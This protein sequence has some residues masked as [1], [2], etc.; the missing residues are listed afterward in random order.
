[1]AQDTHGNVILP[2]KI[3]EQPKLKI[4]ATNLKARKLLDI[5]DDLPKG[6]NTK[7]LLEIL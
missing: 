6:L 1:M 4:R 2:E 5:Q 7:R 3:R